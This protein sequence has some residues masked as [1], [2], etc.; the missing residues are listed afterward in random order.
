MIRNLKIFFA[1]LFSTLTLLAAVDNSV[2]ITE[3]TGTAQANRP[4][5]VSRF[6]A[7]GEIPQYAQAVVAGSPVTTQCDVKT[8]W[9][10][11]S[12][13]HALVTFQASLPASGSLK[14]AFTNQSSGNNT[15][16]LDKAGMLAFNESAPGAGDGWNAEMTFTGAPANVVRNLRAMVSALDFGTDKMRYWM[17]GPLV[18]QVIVEDASAALSQD[19]GFGAN[20]CGTE[21]PCKSLHPTAL[22]TFYKGWL[23]VKVDFIV[24][25]EWSTKL[26]D[27]MYTVTLKTT[28][29]SG[30]LAE[31]LSESLTHIAYTRWRKTFWSGK[32]LP[33]AW[34]DFNFAYMIHSRAVPAFDTSITLSQEGICDEL[35]RD[36]SCLTPS[37]GTFAIGWYASSQDKLFGVLSG[38]PGFGAQWRTDMGGNGGNAR[39]YGLFPS[40]DVRYLYAM[41]S[42]LPHARELLLPV[43]GNAN[44]VGQIPIHL[45]ESAPGRFF[46]SAHAVPAFGKTVSIDARPGFSAFDPTNKDAFFTDP[47]DA[48]TY[49]STPTNSQWTG[50]G[51]NTT[52]GAENAQAHFTLTTYLAYVIS[53]DWYL[54]RE[55]EELASWQLTTGL[56]AKNGFDNWDSRHGSW[57]LMTGQ[58][59]AQAWHLRNVFHAYLVTPDGTPEKQ[60]FQQKLDNNIALLEGRLNMKTGNFYR[61]CTTSPFNASTEDSVWCY[62]FNRRNLLSDIGMT[63]PDPNPLHFFA[64]QEG[65]V[66]SGNSACLVDT[67]KVQSGDSAWHHYYAHVNLGHMAELYS[68]VVPAKRL[69][70]EWVVNMSG[71]AGGF[72]PW[73]NDLYVGPSILKTTRRSPAT[74]SEFM[75]ALATGPLN[76]PSNATWNGRLVRNKTYLI[77]PNSTFPGDPSSAEMDY[78]F[79]ARAAVSFNADVTTPEGNNGLQAFTWIRDVQ[80]APIKPQYAF[81]PKWAILPRSGAAPSVPNRCDVNHDTKVT[82]LD[83]QSI[84]A[85]T[86]AAGD[87]NGDG[88]CSEN[89]L[90]QVNAAVLTGAC[91]AAK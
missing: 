25:N 70:G 90:Q 49:V 76:C 31:R 18:T 1:G 22:L 8:R 9:E 24:E 6:F 4:F 52:G 84:S 3:T 75:D 43:L 45:R 13:Q 73:L 89:D 87:V 16:A 42:S 61:A 17:Q 69:L 34:V 33:D 85:G 26:Q 47:A 46:D 27:Q 40:W 48:I 51:G 14:V 36:T 50:L 11:G 5:T 86:C 30:A 53:G 91:V 72:N 66:A 54:M 20:A 80:M 23:G 28:G 29:A 71:T 41:N 35:Y 19:L 39:E 56:A 81:N 62:S 37:R 79:M 65:G 57:G 32:S 12:L 83:S 78:E 60:Y 38:A 55:M 82:V 15:G 77:N 44:A 59:R 74:W 68:P 2:T 21:K 7:K 10:D 67:D 64:F 63:S 88:V 58:T